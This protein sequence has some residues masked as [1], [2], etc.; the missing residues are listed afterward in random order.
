MRAILICF[1]L[2]LSAGAQASDLPTFDSD[3][4][5]DR[6]LREQS[7]R[8][9]SMANAVDQRG[10]YTISRTTEFPG[11]VA[12]F[13]DGR[14]YIELND[15]L[16]GAH[17]LSV[18]IFELTNLYYEQRHQEVADRVRQ[19]ELNNP[20]AFWLLRETIEYDGLRVHRDVLVELKSVLGTVPPEMITWVSSTTRSFAE[21]QLPFVY[22]YVK[23]QEATGHRAYY[24]RLFEKHRAEYL[25]ATHK[26][27]QKEATPA[28]EMK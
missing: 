5:A 2:T 18:I 1:V 24:I 15:V 14:G 8:Y 21:Y 17:R 12:Y 16:K 27:K 23:A 13:K 6:W 9:R 28:A 7:P 11:G 20:A 26:E 19:G 4:Q 22:D 10:G 25:D 3:Q